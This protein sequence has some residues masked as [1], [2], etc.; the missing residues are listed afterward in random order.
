MHLAFE[1]DGA[2]YEQWKNKIKELD[3]PITH[4]EKWGEKYQSFYFDDPDGHVLEIVP[5]G[6]WG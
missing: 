3:I 5:K 6:M 1:V 4:E 2:E